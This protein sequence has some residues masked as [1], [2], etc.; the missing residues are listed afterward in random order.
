MSVIIDLKTYE[1]GEGGKETPWAAESEHS[2]LEHT[3]PVSRDRSIK[4]R[5][6][7]ILASSVLPK[8]N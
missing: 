1:R 8:T 7:M 3:C 4:V 5:S 6:S 2:H